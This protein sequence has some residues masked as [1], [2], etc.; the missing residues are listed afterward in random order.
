MDNVLLLTVDALR[1]DQPWT[2]YDKVA[3]PALSHLAATALA[4]TQAYSVANLTTPS[5]AAIMSA[6]Y[7]TELTRDMCGLPGFRYEDALAQVLSRAG[8]HTFAAHG[9]AIFASTFAPSQGFVDWKVIENAGGRRQADGAITGDEVAGFVIAFLETE[10]GKKRFFAWA[11]FVDPHDS[12]VSHP[13]FPVSASPARGLY[14]AEVAYTDHQIARVLAALDRA[15]LRDRTAVIVSADHGEAFGEHRRYRHGYTLHD[16]EVRVPLLVQIPHV[17][18][19]RIDV[20]RST[21][22]LARTIASLLG[23]EAPASWRGTSLL[24]DV[25][26]VDAPIARPAIIDVPEIVT[27]RA[28]RAVIIDGKKLVLSGGRLSAGYDL[29]QDPREERPLKVADLAREL[30]AATELLSG[31]RVVTA[32]PCRRE[33]P[34]G[35]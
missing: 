24:Q 17:E 8:V 2:G 25:S 32:E 28:Q 34:P 12:Y 6:R 33:L 3:T 35:L 19:R 5:L 7:P 26:D 30:A 14:D 31:L 9:H 27:M 22:D 16:E 11:H 15:G 4:Y 13:G 29:A 18:P 20:T 23:V 10:A 21:I 1:G